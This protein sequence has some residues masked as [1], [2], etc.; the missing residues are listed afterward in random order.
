MHA[1]LSLDARGSHDGLGTLAEHVGVDEGP[2]WRSRSCFGQRLLRRRFLTGSLD[3]S[4]HGTRG[5]LHLSLHG[6][7]LA[8]PGCELTRCGWDY[9]GISTMRV[10]PVQPHIGEYKR[11]CK[12]CAPAVRRRLR[13]DLI[14]GLVLAE[15]P[16]F[17]A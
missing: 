15:P 2:H 17:G 8:P 4:Q 11:V 9:S 10:T 6:A 3:T 12:T 13:E 1:A 7:G 16:E 5:L 14:A